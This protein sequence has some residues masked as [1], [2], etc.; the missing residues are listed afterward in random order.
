MKPS[1]CFNIAK[2]FFKV[3]RLPPGA[4]GHEAGFFPSKNKQIEDVLYSAKKKENKI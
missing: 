1:R 4:A 3:R 2:P